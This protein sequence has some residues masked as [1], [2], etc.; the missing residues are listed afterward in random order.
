V[1]SLWQAGTL[2]ELAAD[3]RIDGRKPHGATPSG[4]RLEGLVAEGAQGVVDSP[5][6]LTGHR[7]HAQVAVG[8]ALDRKDLGMVGRV[9]PGGAHR[10]LVQR[11]AQR[12][13]TLAGEV[14]L[15]PLG[16]GGVD[17]DVEPGVAHGVIG[18]GEAAGVAISAQIA[19]EVIGPIPKCVVRSARQPG[20][21]REKR[22]RSA[23]SG[24]SSAVSRSSCRRPTSTAWR[25]AG[26]SSAAARRAW[27]PGLVR[28]A[29]TGT[30]W[31]HRVAWTRW[32]H[33]VRSSSRSLYSRTLALASS[34]C[35]GDRCRTAGCYGCAGEVPPHSIL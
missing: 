11:P 15:G 9:R 12:G 31:W 23:R 6:Q 30:P 22:A 35:A 14:A 26:D 24:S 4:R 20:W 17:G 3:H 13:R 29:M 1:T 10:C 33:A 21:R 2:V 18:G 25:P 16:V 27:P 28:E 19:T 7:D 8:A 32:S 34:T 5:G